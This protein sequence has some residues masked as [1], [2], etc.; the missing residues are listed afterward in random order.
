[1]PLASGDPFPSI[2]CF[3]LSSPAITAEGLCLYNSGYLHWVRKL[4]SHT[5]HFNCSIHLRSSYP[6]CG[7][8]ITVLVIE[9]GCSHTDITL[10][11]FESSLKLR[12]G[13]LDSSVRHIDHYVVCVHCS[14]NTT[15]LFTTEMLAGFI[16]GAASEAYRDLSDL[17]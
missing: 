11:I 15:T 7:R 8:N 4:V 17:E 5:H 10:F 12:E 16:F 3:T 9:D 13:C 14:G 1:M 6:H 2:G